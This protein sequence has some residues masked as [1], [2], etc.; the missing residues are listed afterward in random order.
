MALLHRDPQARLTLAAIEVPYIGED[1]ALLLG[2]WRD[3]AAG[4]EDAARA[5]LG[6]L[7]TAEAIAPIFD[8][9]TTVIA[10]LSDAQLAPTGLSICTH[11]AA[12]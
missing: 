1:E 9:M 12:Q 6:L 3:V 4:R 8:A 11:R 10:R 7:V 2:L 5:I